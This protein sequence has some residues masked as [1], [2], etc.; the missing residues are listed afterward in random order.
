MKCPKCGCWETDVKD[1]RPS[2]DAT[3]RNRR[4]VCKN[5][6]FAFST[7]EVYKSDADKLRSLAESFK[8]FIRHMDLV[9]AS[10]GWVE[11]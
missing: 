11:P 8:K 5:C 10:E 9:R 6:L 4:H 1:S 2:K 7:V 3:E